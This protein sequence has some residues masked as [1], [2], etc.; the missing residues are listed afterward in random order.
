MF[1]LWKQRVR[2]IEKIV[3]KLQTLL[4]SETHCVL[5][6]H[7]TGPLYVKRRAVYVFAGIYVFAEKVKKKWPDVRMYNTTC[8]R[9][10]LFAQILSTTLT[11]C[12][13]FCN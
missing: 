2:R 13:S 4:S 3:E 12:L 7:F 1:R 5:S 11:D 8:P 10:V 6:A 9:R